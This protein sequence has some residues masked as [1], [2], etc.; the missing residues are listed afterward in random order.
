VT[1]P[2]LEPAVRV[3][4]LVKRYGERTAVDGLDLTVRRGEIL[5]LLGP[6]GAGKTTT[7]ESIE[8]L[9]VPDAGE[10][11]VL[12][13]DP[14]ADAGRLRTRMGIMLQRGELWNQA[15]VGELVELFA[16][17]Y[18]RPLEPG[19]LLERVGLAGL[20]EARYRGL[21]G[22]ERQ[23]LN[24]AL[25]LVGRPELAILDEP[26]AAMDVAARRQTW[27]LL[28]ELRDGGATVLL[29]T[30][31]LDEAELLADRIA[32]IDHGRLVALGTP[33]ELRAGPVAAEGPRH[34][35]L[36]LELAASLEASDVAALA[37]VNG[38]RAVRQE[39]PGIYALSTDSAG[40]TLVALA[41][42]LWAKQLLP[43]SIRTG[44]SS[45]EE[46]FLRL[47]AE[48]PAGGAAAAQGGRRERRSRR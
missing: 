44:P 14:R 24:L 4:G 6:N 19:Q 42:W 22:G 25:A 39:R 36:R 27:D 13:L 1:A 20:H 10:V 3:A 43:L 7:V 2:L 28:L 37:K 47:V 31:L 11:R 17:F 45:L 8:G 12:G 9:R 23:R 29:T 48:E 15:R 21:S 32:I 35:E 41:G 18:E 34:H 26:T 5:A 40:E 38:V 46:V 30:H 33:A 16:A